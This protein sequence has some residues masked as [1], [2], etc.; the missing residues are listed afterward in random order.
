MVA[1]F[2]GAAVP[3]DKAANLATMEHSAATA[4][5]AGSG[6]IIFPELF[7]TGYNLGERLRPAAEPI[8]GP[9]TQMMAAI[10]RRHRMA[11][12][13]GMP[14][15]DGDHVYNSAVLIDATGTVRSCYRKIH[16]FGD[17][18]RVFASGNHLVTVDLPPYRLG[19]AIC[20]DI[21]FPEVGRALARAGADLI[22]VPTANMMPFT[23][24]ATT[25]VR[26]RALENGITVAYA[27]H[28]GDDHGITYTGQSCLVGPDGID[29]LRAGADTA[30]LLCR[31]ETAGAVT[32]SAPVS[33]QRTD[34][35][36]A[37]LQVRNR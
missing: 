11:I 31:D 3:L 8:D 34:L 37:A 25:L 4:A 19:L 5:R 24:V 20:Y 29:I 7:L 13:V 23:E 27:N 1:I 17:E 21:E 30:A 26:A 16:L 35:R 33:T 15:R 36:E 32:L 22:A 2:Q 6:I 18:N 12:V 9:S 10:A 28:V 14:E